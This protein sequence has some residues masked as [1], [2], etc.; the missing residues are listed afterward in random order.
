METKTV[1]LVIKYACKFY[2]ILCLQVSKFEILLQDGAN[3]YGSIQSTPS[4]MS[5]TS[6]SKSDSISSLNDSVFYFLIIDCFLML[7]YVYHL[8]MFK[9]QIKNKLIN[10]LFLSI[11]S[12]CLLLVMN[13]LNFILRFIYFYAANFITFIVDLQTSLE[14]C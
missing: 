1:W 11:V 7:K 10:K 12:S 4:L 2:Y 14:K 3:S 5:V 9:R 6:S 13:I 8:V